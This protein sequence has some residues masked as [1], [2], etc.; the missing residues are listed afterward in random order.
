MLRPSVIFLL[1]TLSLP[2]RAGEGFSVTLGMGGVVPNLPGGSLSD[3]LREIGRSDG[4]LLSDAL[5]GGFA[6]RFSLAYN[7]LGWSTVELGFTGHGWNLGGSD[8]GGSGHVTLVAHFHPAQLWWPER[9]WDASVFLGGGWS[10]LG[11]GHSD[12]NINRGMY[13]GTLECGLTGRYFILPWLSAG[14]ELRFSV[15]FFRT[16]VVDWSDER[17]SLH[18]SP[19]ALF[20]AI[21]ATTTFHFHTA[22]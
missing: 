7:I 3:S 2:A 14:M 21:L 22:K 9:N 13:G 18:S 1:A 16:W 8:I 6:I 19:S 15:P 12:D 5:S 20:T 4:F 11:G 17:H 10:I